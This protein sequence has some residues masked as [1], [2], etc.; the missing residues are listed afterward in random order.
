MADSS[1][2]PAW[3]GARNLGDLGGVTLTGGGRTAT[4]RVLRSAAPEWMTGRGWAQ[5]REAGLTTVVDLRNAMERGRD[6]RHPVLEAGAMDGVR[7]VHAPTEDPDDP[8]F[9]EAC[10]AWLDHPRSWS[11]NLRLFPERIARVFSALAEAEGAVLLHCAGGRDRTGMI[12]SMLLALAGATPDGIADN[13]EAGFRGAA[14][15]RGHGLAF[16]PETG[17]WEQAADEAWTD[18]ELDAALADRRGVL[19]DWVRTTDVGA[20]LREAGV[21][22]GDVGRARELLRPRVR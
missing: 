7:V 15:H 5:A 18:D 12:G 2:G 3:D 8:E 6:H 17:S 21:G 11:D 22:T 13:Y 14:A 19:I 20:Y 10:G 1:D 9:L 16:S 4:G